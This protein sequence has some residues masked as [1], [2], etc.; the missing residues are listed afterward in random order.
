MDQIIYSF[1]IYKS[2]KKFWTLRIWCKQVVSKKNS[3]YFLIISQ[4]LM[5]VN[6]KLKAILKL[7]SKNN[8][9]E[10]ITHVCMGQQ[11]ASHTQHSIIQLSGREQRDQTYGHFT[12][13]LHH[14]GTTHQSVISMG[15]RCQTCRNPSLDVGAVWGMQHGLMKSVWVGKTLYSWKNKYNSWKPIRLTISIMH[16]STHPEGEFLDQGN[17]MNHMSIS[18]SNFAHQ[19]WICRSH[20]AWWLGLL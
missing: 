11:L 3:V 10:A 18:G 19:L 15:R 2:G 14:W 9:K 7:T 12:K 13:R 16:G 8:N 4:E 17:L 20:R 6:K 5:R 1:I